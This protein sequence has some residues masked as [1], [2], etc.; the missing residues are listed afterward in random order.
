LL[1]GR[2]RP[3]ICDGLVLLVLISHGDMDELYY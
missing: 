1:S 3:I 2:W